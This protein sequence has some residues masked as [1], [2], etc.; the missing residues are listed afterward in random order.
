VARRP[1][2]E[3][4]NGPVFRR[5]ARLAFLA[6]LAL[7]ASLAAC[8]DN[9]T[10][11]AT[12]EI[13]DNGVDD[14][15]NG[16]VDCADPACL[17]APVC[18][19][20]GDGKATGREDCD[21]TD[22]RGKT[23]ADFGFNQGTL[24]C[25][26]SA[27]IYDLR[28]CSV[29]EICD[30]GKD[31]DG[32]GLVDC[33][34]PD[35]AASAACAVCGDG[36]VTGAEQCDDGN[37]TPGDC[38][39][40]CRA[41]PG[42]EIENN[43]T[44]AHAEALTLDAAHGAT[45]RG[46]IATADTDVFT[47][48]IPVNGTAN[49]GAAMAQPSALQR[50]PD[51][52]LEILGADGG[53]VPLYPFTPPNKGNWC[54]GVQA[55]GLPAGP[56]YV[57]VHA[58]AGATAPV[59]SYQLAISLELQ[60]CG[61][62][63]VQQGQECD[64][65]NTR[66]GDGCDHLCRLELTPE[67]DPDDS[68]ANATTLHVPPFA[69]RAGLDAPQNGATTGE[70]WFAVQ[71]A[72]PGNLRAEVLDVSD[73]ATSC[74]IS[75]VPRIVSL[76]GGNEQSYGFVSA[77]DLPACGSV[78]SFSGGPAPVPTAPSGE[79]QPGGSG[80]QLAAGTY[81]VVVTTHTGAGQYELRVT[82][83]SECGNGKVE[84][85][86]Q[87]DGGPACDANCQPIAVCGNG[88]LEPG[89][90]CDDGN[91]IDG[92]GCSSHCTREAGMC[93][94]G[95]IDRGEQCDD[96]NTVGG[97]CCDPMCQVEPGCEVEPDD[98]L[99]T[100]S[101]P[102][103][104]PVTLKGAFALS[105]MEPK[106]DFDFYQLLVR[107]TTDV[108]IT[109]A[110]PPGT[111][112]GCT[113]PPG[114]KVNLWLPREPNGPVDTLTADTNGCVTLRRTFDPGFF[115]VEVDGG[116]QGPPLSYQVSVLAESTCGDLI[117]QGTETCDDGTPDCLGA[118]CKHVAVCGD[119]ILTTPEGCDDG[120]TMA[121]DGCSPT[122]QPEGVG[123]C[124]DG[125]LDPGEEC[126]DGNTK[127]G[128]GCSPDC[129]I[130]VP[131]ARC[132]DGQINQPTEQCDDGNNAN[133]DGCDATCHIEPGHVWETEP[134]DDGTPSVGNSDFKAAAANG[135]FSANVIIHAA[136]DPFGDDDVF[137]VTNPTNAPV[138]V[139][140]QTFGPGGVGTCVG[141]DTVM[142]LRDATA[143]LLAFDDD[144]GIERCSLLSFTLDPQATLYL[145]LT[146]YGDNSIVPLYLLQVT[147]Q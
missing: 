72:R 33:A 107:A 147:F 97:D 34:D 89:E 9:T 84:P 143:A 116:G 92:D 59:F 37:T 104:V 111:K 18:N 36:K 112:G 24:S 85:P 50:C 40:R 82:E 6:W 38:C 121:G 60:P 80:S 65:G 131:Q 108:R 13:C 110:P 27:C 56:A 106:L 39:D 23:C 61:D 105:R 126:D 15:G 127:A 109:S 74:G 47:V 100:A 73:G 75:A 57:R 130:E 144:S 64:D 1:A 21:G 99:D 32:D 96:G 91:T 128:D 101:G 58:T 88:I 5:L 141:V 14:D 133:G 140:A 103:L 55:H 30:N 54:P 67:H 26:A 145:Q 129:K 138:H 94:N 117:V 95:V 11:K 93:G 28:G 136:F 52:V 120:N 119:G 4:L 10:A 41:E 68:A 7:G 77:P 134:N 87:C 62:G 115:A 42:C 49:V 118:D 146:D 70:D 135:P 46:N 102:Y 122:C 76:V 81:Y 12:Q 25:L 83:T 79:P 113:L 16:R 98:R 139:T 71:L 19:R 63:V 114:T 69:V 2:R 90:E 20:C 22:L 29:V 48:V 51:A 31:D 142:R 78:S 66:D 17:S 3:F 43:D 45:V 137:A 35:C 8:G 53:T 132:G 124:G 44:V 86:E 125:H 123:V